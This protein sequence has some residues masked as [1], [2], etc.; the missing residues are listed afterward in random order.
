MKKIIRSRVQQAKFIAALRA[1]ETAQFAPI[2]NGGALVP[3]EIYLAN[4]SR[5]AENYFHE[6]LTNYAVGFRDPND[7]DATRKF[8]APEVETAPFFEYKEA[9]NAEEFLTDDDDRSVIGSDYKVIE[10]YKATTTIG[11]IEDHGLMLVVDLRAVRGQSDW[12]MKKV[13]KLKRRVARNRLK[14]AVALISA[15]ATNTAK[16]WDTTAGKDPD[17]DV[18]TDKITSVTAS[19]VGFNRVG[20]GDTAW[21]KRFL[22]FRAQNNAGGYSSAGMNETQLAGLLGVEQVKVS[23]ERYQSSETAKAEIVNNLVLMFNAMDGA[24]TEDA[25]NIKCFVSR[26]G[27]G[28]QGAGGFERVFIVP[29][30]VNKVGIVLSYQE[31]MKITSTLG[32]RK[33][34]VS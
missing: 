14:R 28:E 17:M 34:T 19:G 10:P 24:D 21:S 9:I 32:I 13:A 27:A 22:S 6:K 23:R 2:D 1:I 7:I 8:F 12:E 20:Y 5:F 30:G 29:L 15:A 4:E 3:G 18:I 25:S 26:Y 16:T 31:L 33:F 11:K